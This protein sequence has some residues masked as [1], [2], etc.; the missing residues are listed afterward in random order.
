MRSRSCASGPRPSASNLDHP[1]HRFADKLRDEAEAAL[2]LR[3][4]EVAAKAD[5][6]RHLAGHV[7]VLAEAAD[8]VVAPLR[9]SGEE[10]GCLGVLVHLGL[11]P[12]GGHR[13]DPVGP[14]HERD[15]PV[16]PPCDLERDSTA[17]DE[18]VA[19]A[20]E[21]IDR[22]GDFGSHALEQAEAFQ[23]T[24]S[25][26]AVMATPARGCGIPGTVVRT[27]ER[28]AGS[29][30]PRA[31]RHPSPRSSRAPSPRAAVAAS[32]VSSVWPENE[33]ANTSVSGP[34]KEG[35]E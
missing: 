8:L 12:P 27:P 31:G 35:S 34:T 32:R 21:L 22:G 28:L 25:G 2:H 20:A 7:P 18:R 29:R 16:E 30:G 23:A 10:G 17:A 9:L 11:P 5:D 3:M 33:T 15:G 4:L 26:A 1:G 13:P 19:P 24:S 6:R 14:Q